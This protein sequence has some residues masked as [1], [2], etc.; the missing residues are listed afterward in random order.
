MFLTLVDRMSRYL[1]CA[2]L[3]KKTAD[4]VD[5]AMIE[6]LRKQVVHSITQTGAKNLRGMRWWRRRWG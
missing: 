3:E 6:A 1:I 4:G 5:A 2:R